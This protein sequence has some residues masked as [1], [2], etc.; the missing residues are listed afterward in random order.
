MV[1][2]DLYGTDHDEHIWQEPDSFWPERFLNWHDNAYNFIPQ[3]G[4]EVMGYRYPGEWAT[5]EE[6]NLALRFLTR[7]M[8]YQVP[9][10]NLKINLRRIP[11][12]PKSRF[13]RKNVQAVSLPVEVKAAR[14][15]R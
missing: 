14:Q 3:G 8:T 7:E 5:I 11:T 4:G 1:L 15:T 9:V 12:L 6:L 10:Q 2:L 13:L